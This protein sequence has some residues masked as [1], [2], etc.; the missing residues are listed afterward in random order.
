MSDAE[1]PEAHTAVHG[2]RSRAWLLW[3]I[4]AVAALIGIWLVVQRMATHGPTITISFRGADGITPGRT[5]LRYK[6]VDVG[7]VASIRIS[8]E[9]EITVVADMTRDAEPFLVRDSRFWVVRPRISAGSVSGLGTLFSGAYISF[10]AGQSSEKATHFTGLEVPPF[11]TEGLA[12]REFVL[13]AS[14]LGSLEVGSPVLFRRVKAGE[15]VSYQVDPTGRGVTLKAFIDAPFDRFVSRDTR[16]W[17]ASGFDVSLDSEGFRLQTQSLAA[18]LDGGVAFESPPE[19]TLEQPADVG[20]QFDIFGSRT[21]AMKRP[22]QESQL[23]RVYFAES[24]RGLSAGAPVDVHG[25]VIGEVARFGL[26]YDSKK[27]IFRFPVEFNVYPQRLRERYLD[28]VEQATVDSVKD[29]RELVNRLVKAGMRAQ[30]KTGNLV[31][32]QLYIGLDFFPKAPAAVID[33]NTPQPVMPTVP[34]GL[35]ALTDTLGDIATKIDAMPL[36]QIGS[37]LLADEQALNVAI[38]STAGLVDHLNS[39]VAPEAKRAL[40]SAREALNAAQAALAAD[41]PLQGNLSD[42]LKQLSRAAQALTDLSDFVEQHPESLI[43]GNRADPQ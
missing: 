14:D 40:A 6:D 27:G 37:Q 11:D 8:R 30:L 38:K 9:G 39:D 26:E 29:H 24:L 16:F 43:R 21:D 22:Y 10:T 34:G 4:P 15:I 1:I 19:T 28:G 2:A 23:Y 25:I 20:S 17:Q 5:V 35:S 13:H 7:T 3:I 12:G 33:W 41:S 32:G 42:T 31:T 36:D 18:I